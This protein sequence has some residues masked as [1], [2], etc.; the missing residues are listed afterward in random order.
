MFI[1]VLGLSG[2]LAYQYFVNV[3]EDH[4]VQEADKYTQNINDK[5]YRI[6]K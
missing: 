4:D 3:K 1:A 6:P 5:L 2:L